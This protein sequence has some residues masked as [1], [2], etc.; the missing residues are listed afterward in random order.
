MRISLPEAMAMTAEND[1]GEVLKGEW[2]NKQE[3]IWLSK[4]VFVVFAAF[5]SLND[6][7]LLGNLR[8]FRLVYCVIL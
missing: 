7:Y 3:L 6:G 1:G 5:R 8:W 4:E 2:E